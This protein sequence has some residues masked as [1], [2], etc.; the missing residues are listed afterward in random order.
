M[1]VFDIDGTI[2]DMRYMML[3][4]LRSYDHRHQTEFF[5]RLTI[6]DVTVHENQMADLLKT[7]VFPPTLRDEVMAW[8][9]ERRWSSDAVRES[10]RPFEGVMEV[11]RWFQMQPRTDVGL[12]TGRPETIRGDTLRSLNSLGTHYKVSFVNELLYMN[13]H[14]WDKSVRRSKQEGIRYFQNGGYRVFGFIDNEPENLM[15]VS[16]WNTDGEILLLHANTLFQ[17]TRKKLPP[18][19]HQREHV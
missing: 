16:E 17:S 5:K 11:I 4:V 7:L 15:A 19:F 1:V 3:H 6:E 18:Q 14:G 9:V 12:N 2:L 13:S 10:H 8:Y